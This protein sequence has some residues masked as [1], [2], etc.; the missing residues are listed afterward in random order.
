MKTAKKL[1]A[2]VLALGLVVC[3]SAMAFAAEPGTFSLDVKRSADGKTLVATLYAHEYTGLTSGKAT[4]TYSGVKLDKVETGVQAKALEN[5]DVNGFTFEKNLKTPGTA[6]C[7]FHFKEAM[8]DAATFT[9]KASGD[10]PLVI[11]TENFDIAVFYFTVDETAAVNDITVDLT[12]KSGDVKNDP[13][14]G[15]YHA[16]VEVVTTPETT[17]APCNPCGPGTTCPGNNTCPGRPCQNACE[18]TTC[19]CQQP[20][21]HRCVKTDGGKETGDNNVIAVMAGVIALAGAAV[22][23]TR[24]RK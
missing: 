14:T 2:V 13:F 12:S 21:Q 6:I 3:L 15:N 19:C 5:N 9:E 22:I 16:T 8:W 20:C 17:T 4:V 18:S 11:D 10:E 1:L 23:V 7:G 24:K